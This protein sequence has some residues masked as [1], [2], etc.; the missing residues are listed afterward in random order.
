MGL[1]PKD[2][3]QMRG[4]GCTTRGLG[5]KP[6]GS[7]QKQKLSLFEAQDGTLPYNQFESLG[8]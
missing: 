5:A 7:W 8:D 2:T 3:W 1:V 6:M 4:F